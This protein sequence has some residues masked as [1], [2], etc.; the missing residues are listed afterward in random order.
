M[1]SMKTKVVGNPDRGQ[2]PTRPPF[3][4]SV[5]TLAAPSLTS[6]R[7]I[8][9]EWQSE[10]QIGAGNWTSPPVYRDGKRVG[11]MSYNGRVWVQ[12]NW[13]PGVREYEERS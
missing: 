12:K 5:I 13:T 4:V 8:L 3:G 10:N 9:H 7:S 2:D 11:F 1:Y 6:L